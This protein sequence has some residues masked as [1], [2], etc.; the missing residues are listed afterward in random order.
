MPHQKRSNALK[1][2]SAWCNWTIPR[3]ELSRVRPHEL[4]NEH[5]FR[6]ILG[7]VQVQLLPEL[8]TALCS[9]ASP[10]QALPCAKRFACLRMLL[11]RCA[12]CRARM[13]RAV[14]LTRWR[15]RG[16]CCASS[17]ASCCGASRQ[18]RSTCTTTA[19]RA[20]KM[21]FWGS[22]GRGRGSGYCVRTDIRSM[23]SG[24]LGALLS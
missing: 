13:R 11:K 2:W 12:L 7:H 8:G 9:L 22:F 10:L 6:C 4:L 14:S 24:E 19:S 16:A 5:D 17:R 23:Y 1:N 20:P 15:L 3:C 18:R 21:H